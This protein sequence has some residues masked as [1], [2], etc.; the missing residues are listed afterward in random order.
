MCLFI[1]FSQVHTIS[2]SATS[3][4]NTRSREPGAASIALESNFLHHHHHHI[5]I[6]HPNYACC[7]R[8]SMNGNPQLFSFF[9][10]W[11]KKEKKHKKYRKFW[12]HFRLG[13][14]NVQSCCCCCLCCSISLAFIIICVLVASSYNNFDWWEFESGLNPC[15][16]T[17]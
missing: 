17:I 13:F 1:F 3:R 12:A 9:A 16:K 4:I 8:K 15:R 6:N 10:V 11:Q 14:A 5:N 7:E 2:N